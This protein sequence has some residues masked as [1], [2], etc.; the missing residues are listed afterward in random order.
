MKILLISAMVVIGL[1]ACSERNMSNVYKVGDSKKTGVAVGYGRSSDTNMQSKVK[2]LPATV[3]EYRV[4]A[5]PSATVF[6]MSG[7]YANNVAVTLG[8][9]GELTYFPAPSDIT[10]DSE[11]VKL[12]DGWW[13]NRQGL[14]P[15]SVFTRYTFAEYAALPTVPTPEQI[16][17]EIIP[18]AKVIEFVEIPMNP[19]YAADHIKEVNALL[20]N[21][22]NLRLSK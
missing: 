1:S 11:P 19:D 9:N 10:A 14:G 12:K 18:G 8:E 20:K 22:N 17:N 6:R 2:T 7:N 15:N 13:L 3:G 4:M 5:V 21:K 16:K